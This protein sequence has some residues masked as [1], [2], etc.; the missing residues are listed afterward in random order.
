MF[1]RLREILETGNA[2]DDLLL[3]H[4][5]GEDKAD[6]GKNRIE[7]D[8]KAQNEKEGT[9]IAQKIARFPACN[10][11]NDRNT[12]SESI[13]TF[14]SIPSPTFRAKSFVPLWYTTGDEEV[15]IPVGIAI[16]SIVG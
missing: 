14:E 9:S 15:G 2:N 7:N 4:R 1:L 5:H 8:R 13:G 3:Q 16:P 6:E 12:H 11:T 10:E